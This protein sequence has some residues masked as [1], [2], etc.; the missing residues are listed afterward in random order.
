MRDVFAEFSNSCF[1]I[2]DASPL[3]VLTPMTLIHELSYFAK[4]KVISDDGFARLLQCFHDAGTPLSL[5]FS[6]LMSH[7]HLPC[8]EPGVALLTTLS[9][10]ISLPGL[11]ISGHSYNYLCANQYDLEGQTASVGLFI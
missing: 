7:P 11:V 4:S 10:E 2:W 8:R 9:G 5:S 6:Y 3:L 1:E